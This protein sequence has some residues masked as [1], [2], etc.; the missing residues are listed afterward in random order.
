[1]A[2]A[3]YSNSSSR[4]NSPP[5]TPKRSRSNSI[6]KGILDSPKLQQQPKQP[7]LLR[8]NT[9][10]D[11]LLSRLPSLHSHHEDL[12]TRTQSQLNDAQLS[13]KP[14]DY[15]LKD[16]IGY[17]SSAVVYGAHYKPTN[18]KVAIKVIDLDMFERNQIDELR[19]E[20]ALMALSKH[21]N[22]LHVYGSFVS[23]SKLYIVTPYLSAGSCLDIMKSS[24]SNGFDEITIATI[25]KQ[26]LEGLIYLHKNGHIHRDV[27]AG[28][29]LMDE[30]GLVQLGD[31]GVSSSLTE[32]NEVRKTFVGTPCWMAPEVMEQAG[33]DFKADIWSF[34]ITAIELATGHAPFSKYAP[35]KVLMMTLSQDP[36]TLP[37]ETTKHKFSK[38]IKEMVDTCLQKDPKK[39][40]SAE[41]LLQHPFFRQAKKK[42]YLVKTI[43]TRV[44]ALERR[45]HKKIP[46]KHI[47]CEST[48]QW[49]F[50]D[51]LSDGG[52]DDDDDD[53]APQKGEPLANTPTTPVSKRH[54]SFGNVVIKSLPEPGLKSP[55][56]ESSDSPA[57][58]S[59]IS[60]SASPELVPPTPQRKS[61]FVVSENLPDQLNTTQ[62]Q[63]SVS[64]VNEL[65]APQLSAA[66]FAVSEKDGIGLGISGASTVT[67]TLPV[68]SSSSSTSSLSCQEIKKGRFSVNQTP[69][70]S[71]SVATLSPEHATDYSTAGTLPTDEVAATAAIVA[72]ATA[73]APV[74]VTTFPPFNDHD[75]KSTPI[76]RVGSNDSVRKSRF[77]IHHSPMDK[78]SFDS[79]P[80]SRN[81]SSAT[82][83]PSRFSVAKE[84]SAAKEVGGQQEPGHHKDGTL[85]HDTPNST[86]HSEC[87]KKGRFQL[88][89]IGDI[90]FD[91]EY[92]YLESPQ[93]TVSSYSSYSSFS[94]G[95][96]ARSFDP[97][98]TPMLYSNMEQLLKQIEVQKT[99]VCD[100]LAGMTLPSGTQAP[101]SVPVSLAKAYPNESKYHDN[102]RSRSGSLNSGIGQTM[103]H[104]QHLL[105][106]SFKEREQ[107][108]KE[109]DD[110]KREL[111]RLRR[112]TVTD[113]SSHH[114][115]GKRN[116]T[117]T[118][119]ESSPVTTK[120]LTKLN[121]EISIADPLPPS[122]NT[123][124]DYFVPARSHT[125]SPTT[126]T[127][128]EHDK[129]KSPNSTIHS[130]EVY[131]AQLS[132]APP[133]DNKNNISNES[134][135]TTILESSH[136]IPNIALPTPSS[137][138]NWT[139]ATKPNNAPEA[140]SDT[141]ISYS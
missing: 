78:T 84:D 122:S 64:S 92:G 62:S 89:G 120:D 16:P 86:I 8:R 9:T 26:A 133:N 94:H 5:H 44:P 88:S 129:L 17:G 108:Q 90:K 46:Q 58:L 27:K 117:L 139:H 56:L 37:R 53:K 96:S 73:I 14:E 127:T 79:L 65:S 28:N 32:N 10:S 15:K 68:S 47:T 119:N 40:P 25:L 52:N 106:I 82:C 74:P 100:M 93:S 33:Y 76:S 115:A 80:L 59:P 70:R 20:T 128:L 69:Q 61:R 4:A 99:I 19:R 95:Q 1:M 124:L 48:D 43:L 42:D 13:N 132:P 66:L 6:R 72:M 105:Q 134:T 101:T 103:D 125:T 18:R 123:K 135:D 107:L 45:P 63:R 113:G 55:F 60:R 121:S 118:T 54:I 11:S 141:T 111:E 2:Q 51:T 36:P 39:R 112:S 114:D 24:F 126:T 12:S 50:D 110:L 109:N 77:A 7:Q 137:S 97:T 21:P 116:P 104:L 30:H 131:K 91:K 22:V 85:P 98:V 81:S 57:T 67:P 38:L 23:G 29:L 102:G 83:K 41:K 140:F 3:N 35:M 87:R 49:D 138:Y 31:F 71:Y 130:M 136:V 34:G 75:L